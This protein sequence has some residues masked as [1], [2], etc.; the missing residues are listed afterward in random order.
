MD[1]AATMVSPDR[2]FMI[3]LRTTIWAQ[4]LEPQEL[5]RVKLGTISASGKPAT[6]AG[7]LMPRSCRCRRR[8]S[9]TGREFPASA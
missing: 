7:V 6:L 1:F 9:A 2:Q 4:A 5:A 8:K 3:S